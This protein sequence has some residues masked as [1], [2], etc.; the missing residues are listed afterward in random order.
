[1]LA[2]NELPSR[3]FVLDYQTVN[4]SLTNFTFQGD[5]TYYISGHFSLFGTNTVEGGAVIKFTNSSSSY[6]QVGGGSQPSILLSKTA[7]YRMAVFTSMNDNSVGET[8]NGSSGSP[9][10]TGVVYLELFYDTAASSNTTLSHLRFVYAGIAIAQVSEGMAYTNISPIWDCQFVNCGN[11]IGLED[12]DN[13]N[14]LNQRLYN[15]LFS[16][17]GTAVTNWDI[18]YDGQIALSGQNVTADHVNILLGTWSGDSC[19]TN[20]SRLTNCILT[21]V[22]YPIYF[23]NTHT[24]SSI[25]TNSCFIS[26]SSSG[27]YQIAGAGSYYLTNGSP[28]RNAGTTN[29]DT[30]LL[31]ELSQKTTYPP[32]VYSN[33]LFSNDITLSVQA[34]RDFDLP[35]LGYHYDPI[36]YLADVLWITNATLTVTNG[37]V[38]A[39]YYDQDVIVSDNSSIVSI[40]TPLL[41]NW[42]TRYSSV[43]EQP[44]ALGADAAN[45]GSTDMIN[46]YHATNAP[47]GQFRFTE[48]SCLAGGGYHLYHG[49][50]N[51]AYSELSVR[52]CEFWSGENDFE[53]YNSTYAVLDNNLFDRSSVSAGSG[54]Y[55]NNNL[56]VSNNLFWNI[57]FIFRPQGNS[58]TWFFFNNDFDNCSFSFGF[59][60]QLSVNGYNA[61]LGNTNR[62]NPPNANDIISTNSLAYQLGPLGNFY[63]PTNSMLINTG[64]VTA[65]LTG[66]YHYTTTTNQVKETNSV[67][68]IGYHYVAVDNNGDPVDTDGDGEPDYLEDANG[69]GIVDIGEDSWLKADLGIWISRPQGI[70]STP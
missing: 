60:P 9:T 52:D 55:I 44:V 63:Q 47:S 5:T 41:P 24:S 26:S 68:D 61:Y 56:S 16:Y 50:A 29:I 69:N 67:V 3:G 48:F 25:S 62:L 64:S 11:A 37:A 20:Y 17:C 18:Y 40:G 28:C 45:P 46:P 23:E 6:L 43:Q 4:S 12:Y 66:L 15:V 8:I 33:V 36:D 30:S 32:L 57:T 65:D 22:S 10:T 19:A 39:G 58:N 51:W 35:D 14:V 54:A 7:P 21:A 27:V 53:G 31:A 34:Q 59:N 49:Q 38:I 13:L 42:I 70:V 2:K 1:M